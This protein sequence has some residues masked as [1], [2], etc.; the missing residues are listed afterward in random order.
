MRAITT[1]RLDMKK[2]WDLKDQSFRLALVEARS[3]MSRKYFLLIPSTCTE[4]CFSISSGTAKQGI[5][6]RQCVR[7][8]MTL[9]VQNPVF[10]TKR[11]KIRDPF[12]N[13]AVQFIP[14]VLQYDV[15]DLDEHEAAGGRP[16]PDRVEESSH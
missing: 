2:H 4:P 16:R 15:N 6:P 8:I 10:S 12:E 7:S 9:L 13:T 5:N 3:Y 14:I 11:S 1:Y